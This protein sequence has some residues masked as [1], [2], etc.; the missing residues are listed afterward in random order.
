[1]SA[2]PAAWATETD[3]RERA[4]EAVAR[5]AHDMRTPLTAMVQAMQILQTGRGG[6]LTETQARFVRMALQNA[7]AL[8]SLTLRLQ[9]LARWGEGG[10]P[11][12]WTRVDA[13][14]A[15]AEVVESLTPIAASRDVTLTAR[16]EGAPLPAWADARLVR[17]MLCNLVGNALKFT[18]AGGSVVVETAA[19]DGH[20]EL[21][22]IDDGPGVPEGEHERVFDRYYQTSKQ[23]LHRSE[24]TGLGL[25]I[26]RA[27]ARAHGGDARCRNNPS[28][29]GAT[30][31]LSLPV[32]GSG[33][34]A[35]AQLRRFLAGCPE[36]SATLV[37]AQIRGA[38]AEALLRAV[39]GG[40]AG[41]HVLDLGS[42]RIG[43][44]WHGEPSDDVTLEVAARLQGVSAGCARAS[45]LDPQE[46]LD[47][48]VGALDRALQHGTSWMDARSEEIA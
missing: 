44:A 20:V 37:A 47:R 3:E 2:T 27:M 14:A 30:F 26:T 33:N 6:E 15:A 32:F 42:G 21:R 17:E 4:T 25:A 36:D 1:M 31:T 45:A 9:E 39:D 40:G 24:G 43:L 38:D 23:R 11:M 48:A 13:P 10:A 22:V 46:L 18:P 8:L 19:D 7:D 28:G 41:A 29:R 34:A 5:I 35:Q 16:C 12:D